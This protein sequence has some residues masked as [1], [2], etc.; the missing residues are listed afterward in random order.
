MITSIIQALFH[1]NLFKHFF[2]K[3]QGKKRINDLLDAE[4]K[5]K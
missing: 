5:T 3:I 1:Q 2:I 4:T